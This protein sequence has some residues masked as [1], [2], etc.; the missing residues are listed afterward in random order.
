[1]LVHILV[2][3]SFKEETISDLRSSS[4][5]NPTNEVNNERGL[6]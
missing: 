6:L 2:C 1:L 4:N 3:K 5:K